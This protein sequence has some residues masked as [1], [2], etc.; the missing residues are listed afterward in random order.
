MSCN[1]NPALSLASY[2]RPSHSHWSGHFGF[3][4]SLPEEPHHLRRAKGPE[5]VEHSTE[6]LRLTC[7][8]PPGALRDWRIARLPERKN[9]RDNNDPNNPAGETVS[10]LFI[11]AL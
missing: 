9:K 8:H 3:P 5:Q 11:L 7:G 2:F 10:S 6:P 1:L 4:S